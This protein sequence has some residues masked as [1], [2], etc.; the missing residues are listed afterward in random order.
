MTEKCEF[1]KVTESISY[2]ENTD[3]LIVERW[4]DVEPILKANAAARRACP[5]FGKYKKTLTPLISLSQVDVD[6]LYALGYDILSPDKEEERRALLYI[7]RHE[8]HLMR[9]TGKPLAKKM[10][11]DQQWR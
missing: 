10:M 2:D 6:R 4:Q 9:V 11:G 5:E 3:M 1:T 7:Q 8:P